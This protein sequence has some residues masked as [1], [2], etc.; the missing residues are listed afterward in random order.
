MIAA[1]EASHVP[2]AA[3][4]WS[5]PFAL[6][7][8][9][10]ALLPFIHKH[11]WERYFAYISLGLGALV[12]A[13]YMT[14]LGHD[15][16]EILGETALEYFKF[17]ALVGSL[18]VVS[19]GILVDVS[20]GGNPRVNTVLLLAGVLIANLVGTTGA[21]VLLIRPFLRINKDRLRPFHIVM[22]IFWSATAAVRSLRSAIRRCFSATSMACL[23]NGRSFIAS[24]R[25][26]W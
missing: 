20:G 22:F 11:F 17:I 7:L 4:W 1:G 8:A 26:C 23:L 13:F 16:R 19:G 21:S 24:P 15:G 14:Q 10:I 3:A 25:G 2:A 5:I 18:F 6:L 9:C 12:A